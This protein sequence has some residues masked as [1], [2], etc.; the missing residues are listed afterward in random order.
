[1]NILD[2]A[3]KVIHGYP[4]GCESLAPR[5]GMA[6]QVLR[7]KANPNTESHHLTL[8]NVVEATELAD[9]DLILETWARERGYVLVKMPT[10]DNCSDGE[11]VEL[12][13]KVWETNGDIGREITR[14]FE[15]GRVERHEV[16]RVQGATWK[17]I[18]VLVGLVS[19]IEGMAE[20]V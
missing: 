3:H 2:A 16:V 15:D 19:R 11:V 18:Q 5:L 6:P 20:P 4:G 17:H 12:M 9:N 14:T 10:A 8:T 7:N 13:A 1:M